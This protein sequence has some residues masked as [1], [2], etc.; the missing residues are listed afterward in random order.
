MKL[1]LEDWL[2]LWRRIGASGDGRAVFSKVTEAYE[3]RHRFYHNS[4]HIEECLNEFRAAESQAGER[5][6]EIE[7]AL[8]LHDF[9]YDPTRNDNEQL[10]AVFAR[11]ICREGELPADFGPRVD[12]LIMATRHAEEPCGAAAQLVVDI[13]LSI[14]GKPAD[15]FWRYEHDV[16]RE[17][18]FVPEDVFRTKRAEIL[19]GFLRRE[20]I[21]HTELFRQRYEKQARENLAA[22]IAALRRAHEA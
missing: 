10:S 7:M 18:L 8:W 21:Y 3:Q 16:R 11:E 2:D 13:D 15:R 19:E 6:N 12:D 9:V 4:E 14:L 1:Q 17:Y 20:V 22:S 5:R